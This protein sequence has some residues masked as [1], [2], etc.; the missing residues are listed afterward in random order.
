MT[1]A[2][3]PFNQ[4]IDIMLHPVSGSTPIVL[5]DIV[6]AS[7]HSAVTVTPS[8]DGLRGRVS[9]D[10][11]S[12]EIVGQVVDIGISGGGLIEHVLLAI[13]PASTAPVRATSLGVTVSAPFTP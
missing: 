10:Q 11:A 6:W 4:Q 12:P 2:N 3:L 9:C 5:T 8:A 13:T 1:T 7:N